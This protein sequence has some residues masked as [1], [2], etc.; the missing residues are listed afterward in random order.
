[1]TPLA[2]TLLRM[3]ADEGVEYI[4]GDGT[5]HMLGLMLAG[6]VGSS[7]GLLFYGNP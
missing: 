1:M 4:L 5:Y 6:F 2:C 7:D 3:Q